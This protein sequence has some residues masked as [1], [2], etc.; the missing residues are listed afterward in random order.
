MTVQSGGASVGL[1]DGWGLKDGD[2]L[3]LSV[4]CADTDGAKEGFPDGAPVG[5]AVGC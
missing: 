4:G 1:D 3:G 5:P 2:A